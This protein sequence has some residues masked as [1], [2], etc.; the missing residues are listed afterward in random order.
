MPEEARSGIAVAVADLTRRIREQVEQAA[1]EAEKQAKKEK[2]TRAI[3]VCIADQPLDAT[4][5]YAGMNAESSSYEARVVKASTNGKVYV[6]SAADEPKTC[7]T[8]G[9]VV[10]G[11]HLPAEKKRELLK[12]I[13][14]TN[15][16]PVL[17]L[18]KRFDA[19][20]QGGK[21][22]ERLVLSGHASTLFGHG[23]DRNLPIDARDALTHVFPKAAAGV[24]SLMLS[25]CYTGYASSMQHYR[26]EFPELESILAYDGTAPSAL[27]DQDIRYFMRA[28]AAKQ[29]VQRTA[30]PSSPNSKLFP[31]TWT[32]RD[33]FQSRTPQT[34]ADAMREVSA[35][36]SVWEGYKSGK[37][38]KERGPDDQQLRLYYVALQWAAQAKDAPAAEKVKLEAKMAE[39][40]AVRHPGW[41]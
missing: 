10:D 22:V 5:V 38:P 27:A 23:V 32:K 7:T 39:V 37:T 4:T 41:Q 34:F 25:A 9:A 8:V 40:M 20:E 1:K 36:E 15:A 3:P 28:T 6:Y 2:E 26:A 19:A 13:D 29:P 30:V 17:A 16:A 24:K 21:P 14:T 35:L 12:V 18:A 11:L 31:T 33:G